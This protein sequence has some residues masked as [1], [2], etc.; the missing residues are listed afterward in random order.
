MINEVEHF[1]MYLFAVCMLPFDECL[2]RS[3]LLLYLFAIEHVEFFIFWTSA[4][5]QM[6]GLCFL[7]FND[8][9]EAGEWIEKSGRLYTV[10]CYLIP[11][12][13]HPEVCSMTEPGV[14]ML[15]ELSHGQKLKSV[16]SFLCVA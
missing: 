14:S 1:F 2:L 5:S 4:P 15:A 10:E 8:C 11:R 16:M 12:G 6:S 13:Q 9:T 7:P 3:T